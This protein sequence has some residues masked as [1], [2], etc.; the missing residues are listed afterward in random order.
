MKKIKQAYKRYIFFIINGV[1]EKSWLS[2]S[3]Q[4]SYSTLMSRHYNA[5]VW[6][7]C[8][9]FYCLERLNSETHKY[10]QV[11]RRNSSTLAQL[12]Q[13]FRIRSLTSLLSRQSP[14]MH[15]KQPLIAWR[16]QSTICSKPMA[17]RMENRTMFHSTMFLGCTHVVHISWFTR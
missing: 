3:N 2:S 9:Q 6:I 1:A 7:N 12:R 5:H 14:Q 8:L 15:P 10:T 4:T 11:I 17:S 13:R 16:P